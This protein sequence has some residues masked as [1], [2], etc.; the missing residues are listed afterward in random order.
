V[1]DVASWCDALRGALDEQ[2]KES[3][4]K[5]RRNWIKKNRDR[6]NEYQRS[7]KREKLQDPEYRAQ[8][9]EY[10]RA[11]YHKR[12]QDPEYKRK[13]QAYSREYYLKRKQ[14]LQQN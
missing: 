7:Y 12:L 14:T 5:S 11:Y 2:R 4:N 8:R 9:N 6:F 1:A 13:R 3:R 10:Q